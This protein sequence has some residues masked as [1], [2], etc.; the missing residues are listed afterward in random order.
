[1]PAPPCP[2]SGLSNASRI[3]VADAYCG[4]GQA[5]C[6]V[7]PACALVNS[8]A[9]DD[10]QRTA[11]GI[12]A[13]GNMTLYP[14]DAL[15]ILNTSSPLNTTYMRLP[16]A[17]GT[18]WLSSAGLKTIPA[19]LPSELLS[20][21]LPDNELTQLENLPTGLMAL[22][23]SYNDI[24][25]IQNQ[26]WTSIKYIDLSGN[27]LV[28]FNYVNL[29][30]PLVYFGVDGCSLNSFVAPAATFDALNALSIA[31]NA[32]AAKGLF[33]TTLPRVDAGSRWACDS[34]GGRMRNLTANVSIPVCITDLPDEPAVTG[35]ALGLGLGLGAAA[36]VLLA[37]LF[38]WCR[39]RRRERRTPAAEADP[40]PTQVFYI[41]NKTVV[42][43]PSSSSMSALS[44]DERGVDLDVALLTPFKIASSA[45]AVIGDAPMATGS[46]VDVWRGHYQGET[47]VIKRL[48][49]RS[50]KTVYRFVHELQ[51]LTQVQ[52]SYYV[53]R[54]YGVSW[55]RPIDMECVIE[56]M[57]QGD[58]QLVL[59]TQPRLAWTHKTQYLVHVARGLLS[60]HE[61]DI[62]HRDLQARHVLLDATR[63]AKL[64]NFGC[65]R[66]VDASTLTNGIGTYQWMAPEVILSTDYSVSADMYSF[67]VFLTELS[68]HA[69]P[70]ADLIDPSTH[71]PYSQQYIMTQVTLGALRP[72]LRSD[73][74]PSWVLEVA[75]RCMAFEPS[76]R[77]T[78]LELC[79]L[80]EQYL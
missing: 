44:M 23:V 14:F 27:R 49:D 33:A 15:Y 39:K 40:K 31:A 52:D 11:T 9:L 78:T 54:L 43:R 26:D 74:T 30:K 28:S 53:V 35:Y 59:M 18:L 13:I 41:L 34:I 76:E 10:R 2:Y 29:S 17:L 48:R 73:T 22:D 77:P 47:V 64:T 25:A 37:A 71:R 80:L 45:Y 67:G 62:I 20:L 7:S 12:D 65:S 38:W 79:T 1:M 69:V 68:T 58:L 50:P 46:D 57:D 6:L 42:R 8:S 36:L 55:C 32:T 61:K 72:R 16:D 51:L 19:P 56:Y 60:L 63:G 75:Q 24:E 66:Q 21:A 5:M 3:L 70:Y 4:A